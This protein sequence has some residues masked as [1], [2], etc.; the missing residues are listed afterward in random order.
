MATSSATQVDPRQAYP[1]PPF[2]PQPQE[3][4]GQSL[5]MTPNP[6]YGE[7]TYIGNGKLK[8]RVALIT[9]SDSGI[10][11]A[12]ALAFAREG[13]DI[14]ISYLNEDVDAKETS[15]LVT[16]SGRRAVMAPGDITDEA[17]A[18]DL[19]KRA[20]DE[21]GQLDILVNNAAH[22]STKPDIGE[23]SREEL[24][25][26]F[27]TNVFAM[28]H[29][30][31]EAIKVMKPGSCVI[32]TA[33]VQAYKPSPG[34]LAYAASKGAIVDF[35]KAFA[36]QVI[37]KGIRVNAVAPGPVWTPLIPSTMP[38]EAVTNFGEESLLKRP[39]QP[40]ELAPIYVLLAS[41]EASYVTGMVY[42]VTGG[43]PID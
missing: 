21:F 22:Q 28:F 4:P 38:K 1:A 8:G 9:G 39:A 19:I 35:T 2:P 11:R 26:T 34:L 3:P 18:K 40:A 37:E 43:T 33:S 10:G 15:R 25:K 20:N 13:A 24:E 23:F 30:C 27:A 6:D 36:A 16:E 42:G 31:Q 32:N 14:V 17:F 41:P 7:D 5:Q 29:I 12:V